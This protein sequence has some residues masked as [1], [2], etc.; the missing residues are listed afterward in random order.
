MS[1][2]GQRSR[3]GLPT[4]SGHWLLGSAR[5]FQA[6]PH[7]FAAEIGAAH[8][9]LA[10]F[11][12]LHRRLIAVTHPDYLRQVL[13]TRH[14]RYERSFQY[15]TSRAI[16]GLGLI[17]TDGPYWKLRRRQ[18]QPAFRPEHLRRI[19]PAA[20]QASGEMFA[21][22]EALRRSG[23]PIPVV[24][25]MQTFTLTVMC[26]ALLSVGVESDEA[27]AFGEAL[28]GSLA[29]VRRKNTSACPVAA[30]IPTSTNRA[31]AATR[32]IFDGFL[33]PHLE[34]RRRPGAEPRDDIVQHLLEARDPETGEGLPWPSLLDETK[35]LFAAGFE[36]TATAL[37]WALHCLSHHPR[38]A[39][40]WHAEVDGVLGGREPVWEDLERLAG[41]ARIVDETLR[42]Y[43]PVYTMGRV[44]TEDD[45]LGGFP[46][47]RGDNLLLSIYGAHRM[48]RFWPEPERFDPD[49]FG[50]GRSWERHA[51]LPFAL[52]KHQCIGNTFAL[53]EATLVLAL[54]GQ[55]Y[56]LRP[57]LPSAVPAKAQVTLVP[58][59]EIPMH[60]DPR[61]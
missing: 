47:R 52:G 17:T 24:A 60:L 37:A 51:Y 41:T 36:T 61:R 26:R 2:S 56:R 38:A 32:R 19:L 23:Q 42:L 54:I 13:V 9:G 30:W 31:L 7:R 25:E 29:L 1:A 27:H 22:W 6:A 11:R 18:I 53:S 58:A 44:C 4:V 48:A 12:V 35:T 5:E 50:P 57:T 39:E 49:R 10:R 46:I 33:R 34:S 28:R 55:R 40:A 21:R 15:R 43:P 3:S 45:E 14:E 20:L 59:T 16:V 8:G